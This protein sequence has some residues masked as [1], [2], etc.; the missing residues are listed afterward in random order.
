MNSTALILV[1]ASAVAIVV[2]PR[3]WAPL[4]LLASACYMTTGQGIEIGPL[5][6]P[7][8]RMVLAIGL[9]RVLVRRERIANGLNTIDKLMIAWGAWIVFAS[10]FHEWIPGSGPVYAS[11]LV[12][13]VGSIYL[14]MRIWCGTLSELSA[15][16]R[17]V[18][19]VL[20]PVACAM[21]AE[22]AIERNVFAAFGGI[23]EVVQIRDGRIRAQ[24]PFQHAILAGIAGA[25]CTPLMMSIWG[26]YR[27][28]SIV[29]LTAS[30]TM[31]L[32][33]TSSTPLM[34]L[35]LAIG[36]VAMWPLRRWLSLFRWGAI[37]LYIAAGFL[38]TRPAYYLIS[39]I[40]LTGSSTGWYRSR[41]IQSS[42]EHLG[43]WWAF[44]TDFT[45]HWMYP[46]LDERHSD[47]TNYYIFMGT[48]GG[49]LATILLIAILW[50]A[51]VWVGNV[52]RDSSAVDFEYR[53]MMWCMGAGLF[54]H[55]GSSLAVAYFDQSV[56]FLWLNVGVISAMYSLL[57]VGADAQKVSRAAA[58]R[59]GGSGARQSLS[60]RMAASYQSLGRHSERSHL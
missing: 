48:I 40:D 43:E 9:L 45:A 34:A 2:L 56:V 54:A 50:R 26:K 1:I 10:F 51:F 49:L 5:S 19:W 52:V 15:T 38:M 14:L 27:I 13:N 33:S 28:S 8:Y 18:A 11:G 7:V 41:L 31:V 37:S 21:V 16:V 3:S 6:F 30:T 60:R 35:M 25:V 58:Q 42:L 47:I 46:P 59:P 22:H 44:G 32:A 4:P 29:G 53:F 17:I 24:G 55:A 12:F 36:G 39:K 23:P 20:V 57:M